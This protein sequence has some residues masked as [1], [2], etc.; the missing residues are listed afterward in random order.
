MN[1]Y[2][3]FLVFAV[4]L[5]VGV[6]IYISTQGPAAKLSAYVRQANQA[7]IEERPAASDLQLI[8]TRGENGDYLVGLVNTG[9]KELRVAPLSYFSVTFEFFDDAGSPV[10]LFETIYDPPEGAISRLSVIS[11][12]AEVKYSVGR[13][14][15]EE[16][17]PNHDVATYLVATYQPDAV[18]QAEL[19]RCDLA[20]IELRSKVLELR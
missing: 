5:V 13:D 3:V 18:D 11:P 19:S 6:V 17:F 12:K 4:A 16:R 20:G 7:A 1:R 8:L 14:F 9:D 10:S 15:F 2:V